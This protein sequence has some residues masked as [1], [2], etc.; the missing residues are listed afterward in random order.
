MSSRFGQ[1][2]WYIILILV[3]ALALA[4]DSEA[5]QQLKEHM[6]P[7]AATAKMVGRLPAAKRLRL[8]IG[9]PL[10]N[11][12]ELATLLQDLYDPGSPAFRRFLTPQDF[13]ARFGPGM[14]SYESVAEFF[15]A[16]GF[17]IVA[18]HPNRVLLDVEAPAGD[19][20]RTLHLTLREYQHP[21]EARTFFAP[22][23]E[24]RIDL[25]VPILRISGLDNY[26]VPHPASLHPEPI[27]E[28]PGP[29]PKAGSG[30]NGTYMGKDFRA[31]YAPGVA[32]SGAGQYVGL[33]QFD[34]YYPN[35]IN[36]YA[37]RAGLTN[38]PL[39]NVLLDGFDGSPGQGNVEVALDIEVC[40]A[41]APGLAGI[42]VYEGLSG[43]D[44]LNRM[45]TDNLAK[46]LSASWTYPTD[47]TT[48]TIF[49]QMAAQGQSYFNASGDNGA[50]TGVVSTPADSL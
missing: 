3:W 43:N 11:Q 14:E 27:R 24:P 36:V 17:T 10:R 50:Y 41:M 20:E 42:I 30:P 37:S 1:N 8:T 6:L 35:D 5:S 47:A 21:Q 25:D 39:I 45:A 40:M 2:S 22:D 46:Q 7:A 44:I 4:S 9:L 38:V 16:S 48:Q 18:T 32:L 31:A 23:S 49:Q 15:K 28:G 12:A 19:I 34:G 29:V 26:I 33:L 13:A